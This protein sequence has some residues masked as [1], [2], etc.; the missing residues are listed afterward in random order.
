MAHSTH[1]TQPALQPHRTTQRISN[2]RFI[3]VFILLLDGFETTD[4]P[5]PYS[6]QVIIYRIIRLFIYS[7]IDA[8]A[9]WLRGEQV[10]TNVMIFFFFFFIAA[11]TG[12]I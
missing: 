11:A 4:G 1:S 5:E 9:V 3:Y 8:V 2:Y 10:I 12:R 7:F 6:E